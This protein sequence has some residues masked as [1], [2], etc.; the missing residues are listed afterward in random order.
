MSLIK[1]ALKVKTAEQAASPDTPAKVKLA[2]T[3][4]EPGPSVTPPK[5]PAKKKPKRKAKP[6]LTTLI[7]I[8]SMVALA[9]A[10]YMLIKNAIPN[11]LPQSTTIPLTNIKI[12]IPIS[13]IERQKQIKKQRAEN[14][15]AFATERPKKT[16]KVTQKEP[17]EWPVI[18]LSGFGSGSDGRLAIING[19]LVSEG[20]TINGATLL[21][22]LED[23]VI[24]EFKGETLSFSVSTQ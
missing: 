4:N 16:N 12:K 18:R 19:R 2:G 23:K 8:F 10:G 21:S 5:L 9:F 22:V 3:S 14:S 11:E 7:C 13:P 20:Q 17:I 15:P 24:M 1:E 6:I